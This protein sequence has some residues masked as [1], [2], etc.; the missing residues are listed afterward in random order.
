[1]LGSSANEGSGV[2]MK[3]WLTLATNDG[4]FGNRGSR[5]DGHACV[6]NV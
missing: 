5:E 4:A 2:D 6:S 3:G 1:M